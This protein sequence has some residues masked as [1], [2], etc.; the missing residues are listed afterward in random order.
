[1]LI[2]R[3]RNTLT[4]KWEDRDEGNELIL[5]MMDVIIEEKGERS[6]DQVNDKRRGEKEE[7]GKW[8]E[9]LK[10]KARKDTKEITWKKV[11]RNE[12]TER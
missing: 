1:M 2:K 4:G 9:E 6:E 3:G 10:G 8:K 7:K 5:R 11:Q 12:D